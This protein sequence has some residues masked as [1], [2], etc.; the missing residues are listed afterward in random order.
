MKRKAALIRTFF[1][2][3]FERDITVYFAVFHYDGRRHTVVIA[4]RY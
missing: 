2:Y 3:D 4:K 1:E